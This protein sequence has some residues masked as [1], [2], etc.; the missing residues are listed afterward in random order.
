M[1]VTP[2]EWVAFFTAIVALS[3]AADGEARAAR[4]ARRIAAL[5]KR[6]REG[7]TA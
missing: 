6:L 2:M 1:G 7:S 3:I 5:E 4:M